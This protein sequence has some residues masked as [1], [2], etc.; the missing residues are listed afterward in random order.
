MGYALLVENVSPL[1]LLA[2]VQPRGMHEEALDSDC[3]CDT[4]EHAPARISAWGICRRHFPTDRRQIGRERPH[5]AL[6]RTNP[7]IE[8]FGRLA[9]QPITAVIKL[10]SAILAARRQGRAAYG[11]LFLPL[12]DSRAQ[13]R[14][15][16]PNQSDAAG[17]IAWSKSIQSQTS[18]Q[19]CCVSTEAAT[20]VIDGTDYLVPVYDAALWRLIEEILTIEPGRLHERPSGLWR[21]LHEQFFSRLGEIAAARGLGGRLKH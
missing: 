5:G 21:H 11:H 10:R 4:N 1:P 7:G 19:A 13:N 3:G 18:N 12:M 17:R 8:R 14:S 9:D 16:V 2:V 15:I 20:N 6:R